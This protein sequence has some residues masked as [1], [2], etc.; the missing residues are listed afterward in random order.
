MAAEDKNNSTILDLYRSVSA[1]L[2]AMAMVHGV[3][4]SQ[5]CWP[6]TSLP[7]PAELVYRI[8]TRL[9]FGVQAKCQ[10]VCKAWNLLLRDPQVPVWGCVNVHIS[11]LSELQADAHLDPAAFAS[12]IRSAHF[13][14]LLCSCAYKMFLPL[15]TRR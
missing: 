5:R 6:Q 7:I 4:E 15:P 13:L 1:L 14:E 12:A 11:D 8:F 3:T 2:V 9:S 10:L